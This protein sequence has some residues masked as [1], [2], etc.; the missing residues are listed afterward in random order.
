[1]EMRPATTYQH[2]R[3]SGALLLLFLLCYGLSWS[4]PPTKNYTIK[5]GRMVIE[6]SKHL[7]ESSLD[8]FIVQFDLGE[9]G[10]KT[11][12]NTGIRDSLTKLGWQLDKN[13]VNYFVISKTLEGFDKIGNPAEK[14]L[15]TEKKDEKGW[16]AP[17]STTQ[18]PFGVN[19]F[20]NKSDFRTRDSVVTF[21]LRGY[22]NASKV[23]LSGSFINWSPTT[24][25]MTLTDSGW[26]RQVKLGPGK[27]W[28]KFIVDGN[29]ITDKDNMNQENDGEGNINSVYYKPNITI[30]LDSFT[31]AKKVI[32]SGSFNEWHRNELVMKPTAT[33]W[34]LSLYLPEG[35]HTYRFIVDGRWMIDP[36]NPDRMPNEY[37]D[38]NS[39]IKIGKPYIFRLDGFTDARQVILTGSF[40]KWKKDE[41]FMKRTATGWELPYTLGA[42]NYS[43]HFIIDGKVAGAEGRQENFFFVIDPNYKFRL[44]GFAQAKEVFLAGDFNDW[45]PGT[46]RMEK[47]GD[48]WVF[49]VHLTPGKH[50]YKFVVDGKWIIDPTNKNW[51]QNEHSTG[52]SVIWV[53]PGKW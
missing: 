11:F 3:K 14:I 30:R 38:F 26:I 43:Y 51:E 33:G 41:L 34:A 23:I 19:Q 46:F 47:E 31:Q 29:W 22:T 53:E 9:L 27:H 48:E 32:L 2:I 36:F 25:G 44:K 18:V 7:A 10:I 42:G 35:T 8:S 17:F 15:F 49:N 28:Y 5:N 45:A 39:V 50:L 20:R 52:N 16:L 6:L 37:H 1:M 13:T 40:N 12:I 24:L 4:Q 21:F